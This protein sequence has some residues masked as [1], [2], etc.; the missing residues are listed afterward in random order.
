MF[1]SQ[2]ITMNTRQCKVRFTCFTTILIASVWPLHAVTPVLSAATTTPTSVNASK[3][4]APFSVN[5]YE[6]PVK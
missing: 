5:I 6:F 3:T 4:F 2:G 1:L